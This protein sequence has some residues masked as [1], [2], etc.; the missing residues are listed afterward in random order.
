MPTRTF[1][2]S[3]RPG[4][5]TQNFSDHTGWS[6][7]PGVFVCEAPDVFSNHKRGD[8]DL[9]AAGISSCIS[10][11]HGGDVWIEARV[12]FQRGQKPIAIRGGLFEVIQRSPPV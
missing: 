5:S 10:I 1:R 11:T 8:F 9:H 3:N 6:V 2:F 12:L 4:R 7:P